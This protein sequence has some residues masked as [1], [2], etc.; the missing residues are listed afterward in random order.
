MKAVTDWVMRA[1]DTFRA[2]AVHSWN[3]KR[4]E[5]EGATDIM[6]NVSNE[7]GYWLHYTLSKLKCAHRTMNRTEQNMLH[8]IENLSMQIS[9]AGFG[10]KGKELENERKPNT[11]R[12]AMNICRLPVSMGML[13][14]RAPSTA[15]PPKT[16]LRFLL[17]CCFSFRWWRF[18]LHPL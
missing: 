6:N 2:G 13:H 18:M 10:M 1:T 7:N 8:F 14:A 15:S 3:R 12:Y 5:R 11:P 4:D 9:C 16:S 17:V